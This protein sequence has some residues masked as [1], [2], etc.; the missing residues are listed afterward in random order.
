MNPRDRKSSY[1]LLQQAGGLDCPGSESGR[2][3]RRRPVHSGD[4]VLVWH[5]DFYVS[6]VPVASEGS[7]LERLDQKPGPP[8]QE[9]SY[10]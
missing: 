6:G 10:I 8:K 4:D 1:R 9:E 2:Q 3:N 7:K 5:L